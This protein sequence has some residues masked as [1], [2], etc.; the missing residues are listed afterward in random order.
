MKKHSFLARKPQY[1]SAL[2]CF[3][4]VGCKYE[5]TFTGSVT[6]PGGAPSNIVTLQ[7]YSKNVRK[8]CINISWNIPE[9]LPVQI[10]ASDVLDSEDVLK[11]KSFNTK[12]SPCNEGDSVYAVGK[13][14]PKVLS[15][16]RIRM[17]QSCAPGICRAVEFPVYEYVE[18]LSFEVKSMK[19]DSVQVSFE[20]QGQKRSYTDSA[21]P[22]R[23]SPCVFQCR[24]DFVSE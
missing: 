19:D 12:S 23:I 21:R 20:G 18:K 13:R 24:N 11:V 14:E 22:E 9:V 3:V 1:L 4:L 8:F 2:V 17:M 5:N 7:A 6:R 15:R 10:G 16:S